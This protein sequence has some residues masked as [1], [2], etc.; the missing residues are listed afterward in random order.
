MSVH[1]AVHG[2]FYQ[3]PR[4]NPWTEEVPVEPSAAPFHDW[5]A[6]IEA[7]SY[8]PNAF[9]R[10][11]D[12]H[13]MVVAIV[14][15]YAL[16]GFNLGPTLAA[17]LERHAAVTYGRMLAAD[18]EVGTAIAQAYHH[19]ILPLATGR[20]ARTEIRWGLAD[21]EHRF[22]RRAEGIWLPE[23]AVNDDVLALLVDEGLAYTILG[24]QQAATPVAP[25]AS[26]WWE[27]PDGSGRR[28]ALVFFDGPLS[29]DV[30]FGLASTSA[31]A[32]VD[33]AEAA[34]PRGG[35]VVVATDGETFGHHH[36]FTERAIAYALAVEAPRR[37]LEVGP[38]AAWLAAHPPVTTV[39]IR[40]SAWSCAHGVGRWQSDCG[41]STGGRP[42]TNQAWREPL[43]AALDLL[44]DHAAEVFERRGKGVFQDPWEARDGYVH[45]LLGAVAPED[46]VAERGWAGA[47]H[48]EALTLL[49]LQ[50]QVLLMYTSCGWFF[51]DLAGIETIQI[52]RYAARAMDL[53]ADLGE[54]PPTEAFLDVLE[55]AES[56][57]LREGNGRQVWARHVVPARVGP[58][59]VVAH[60]AL[61][62]LLE[63]TSPGPV[64]GGYEVEIEQHIY[65]ERGVAALC[66][67]RA[68]LVHRR[69][70]R[71]QAFV[72][73]ALHLGALDV[74][75]ACRPSGDPDDDAH[76][77]D[78]LMVRWRAGDRLTAVLRG[79][80]QDFGP[81]EFGLS[82]A[83]PGAEG[84]ILERTARGLTDRF[85]A[86]FDRLLADNRR[87]L[88]ALAEAGYP[89]PAELRAPVELALSR[90]L[91]GDLVAATTG[92]D[93][94]A[95]QAAAQTVAE[96]VD[97][98]VSPSSGEVVAAATAALEA[99]TVRAVE[100]QGDEA[101]GAALRLVRL[102]RDAG[103]EARTDRAQEVLYDVLL[104]DGRGL[105]AD[106]GRELGLA[107]DHL[108][109]PY[110]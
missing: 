13:G 35:L 74:V 27:H 96:A 22:G 103:I 91:L 71:S 53:M 44:R 99:L 3:P 59:R 4:E 64:V 69:T 38:I 48:I 16:L 81:G 23:T 50:R 45:V 77:V 49:E 76:L 107:V 100:R 7:E 26:A 41:C 85:T 110:S 89:L 17:W 87:S 72:F 9:A 67:G 29:H 2:H 98:G 30:A 54:A 39:A 97:A 73:A 84:R 25:G 12:D 105:L 18:A 5:N 79:I 94:L 93:G 106:L 102:L 42:G 60:L 55:T 24:P 1:L 83:L 82:A 61:L 65:E 33:R 32:L 57:E 80:V 109:V 40:E 15:N 19:S 14:N 62:E 56:N 51:H 34:A 36:P 28:L 88:A 11:V 90:R 8:R 70:R 6:R 108:G 63:G 58:E 68:R 92:E 75:G 21:F 47:D 20:D 66:A 101:V 10:I 46:Y 86:E 95:L 78:A 104:E 43:R 31:Q 52:L 37:E